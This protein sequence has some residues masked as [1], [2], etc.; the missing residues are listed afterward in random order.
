MIVVLPFV[1]LGLA[2]WLLWGSLIHPGDIVIALVLYTITGLGVTVGF[3]RGLTHG[4]Y[5]A[6]RPVRIALAVAGR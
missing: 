2:G 1:A 5:R 4:G 6:V 3:H